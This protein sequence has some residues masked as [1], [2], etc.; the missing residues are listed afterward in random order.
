MNKVDKFS[1]INI[2]EALCKKGYTYYQYKILFISTLIFILIEFEL[3]LTSKLDFL[4]KM[5]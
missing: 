4:N 5:T 2:R 3:N 1:E